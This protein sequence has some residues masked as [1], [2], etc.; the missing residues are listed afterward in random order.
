MA[1]VSKVQAYLSYWF[2]LGKPVIFEKDQAECLPTSIFQGTEYSQAF[3]RCWQKIM[4]QPAHCFLRG[5]D[6]SIAKLLSDEWEIV[7]CSRCPMPLPM[8]VR[9]IKLS[10]CPCADLPTWPNE[11]VPQPRVAIH[12]SDHLDDIRQRLS[13]RDQANRDR[14]QCT[15][16]HSPN[17]PLESDKSLETIVKRLQAQ[18]APDGQ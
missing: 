1:S 10:P 11:E 5:T 15:Y 4:Q 14:L 9:G 18:R 8:P 17:L 16:L 3:Q 6:E 13:D 12:N 7:G 2:Q